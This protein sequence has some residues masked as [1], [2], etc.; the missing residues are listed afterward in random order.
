MFDPSL[1]M[2]IY[3][4]H[5][6]EKYC[7]RSIRITTIYIF[8]ISDHITGEIVSNIVGT[9]TNLKIF[10]LICISSF[11]SKRW[12]APTLRKYYPYLNVTYTSFLNQLLPNCQGMRGFLEIIFHGWRMTKSCDGADM[13]AFSS[14]SP[15]RFKSVG[16]SK[17]SLVLSDISPR[18]SQRNTDYTTK[19]II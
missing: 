11:L 13:R 4:R 1:D 17:V 9:P 5:L 15:P 18:F 8:M 10:L 12:P 6:H 19:N 7:V 16:V 2:S 14:P 3:Q